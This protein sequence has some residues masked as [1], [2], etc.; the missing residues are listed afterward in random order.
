MLGKLSLYAYYIYHD[1]KGTYLLN[2][3]GRL[4]PSGVD[5]F[6]F[7]LSQSRPT[8]QPTHRSLERSLPIPYLSA[9]I[10]TKRKER[11]R[12]ARLSIQP[13][14]SPLSSRSER[15]KAIIDH[16]HIPEHSELADDSFGEI[17]CDNN[18][19]TIAGFGSL[20]SETSARSTFPELEN[21]RLGR[22]D[23]FRRV[24]AHACA[25][26]FDRG[27]ARMET[28][29]ISS[30]SVEPNAESSIIVSLFEVEATEDSIAAFIDREHEFAFLRVHPKRL[31]GSPDGR[32]AVVCGKNTDEKYRAT[33][34]P[35]HVWDAMYGRHQLDSLWRD[36][37]LPCRVYLRHCV[38]A[39]QKLGLEAENNFLDSTVLA[40][41]QTTVRAWLG[42]NP[43][44]ME[45]VPP[46]SLI[47]RYSG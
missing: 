43:D 25:I 36:D 21:F 27:I 23:G 8:I 44:I 34:C 29:E 10:A 39:A 40:D 32:A 31:D 9:L 28:K 20:L 24:F 4:Q 1:A 38:L 46:D 14:R 3:M 15:M 16:G 17:I 41:R 42:A 12:C 35:P 7:E 2:T 26:F 19:M 47:G 33:R 5:V 22:I 37:V 18:M 6:R 45:E 30:L 11:M 13:S